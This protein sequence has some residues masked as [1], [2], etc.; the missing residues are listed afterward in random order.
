MHHVAKTLDAVHAIALCGGVALYL[1]AHVAFLH[2]ATGRIFRHRT[3]GGVASL[4][5]IPAALT[6]PALAAL[7]L[8]TAVCV[9]V[10]ADEVLRH[11]THRMQVRHPELVS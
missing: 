6:L 7:A 9:F 4:A 10:V 1:L 2:R 5:L 11:R 3:I 8:V